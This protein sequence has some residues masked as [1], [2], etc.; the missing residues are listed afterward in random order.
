MEK[1]KGEYIIG[2]SS[3]M[4]S[5]AQPQEKIGMIDLANKA[6]YSAF[7]GVNFTQIDL[8]MSNEFMS[9][10]LK[11]KIE[12]M[13]N[14][15]KI[16]F[17]IHGVTTATG[18]KGG[19]MFLDSA[20][21]TEY[22]KAHQVLVKDLRNSSKIGAKYHLQHASETTPYATLGTNFQ[23][24]SLV[25]IWGRSLYIFLEE[26]ENLFEWVT[27]QKEAHILGRRL[28]GNS[29]DIE[30]QLIEN[31]DKDKLSFRAD[32]D[33]R[34]EMANEGKQVAANSPPE[35]REEYTERLMKRIKELE[36]KEKEAIPQR[37]MHIAKSEITASL[38][39]S[40]MTYGP[41]RFAYVVIAKWMSDKRDPIWL[42]IVGDKKFED[43]KN[44]TDLWVPAVSSKYIWGHFHPETCPGKCPEGV[45][46]PKPILEGEDG[47]EGIIFVIE[48]ATIFSGME[49]LFRLVNP[50]HMVKLSKHVRSRNFGV[51]IDFE[52]CLGA[53]IKPLKEPTDKK[54]D[55]QGFIDEMCAG[56]ANYVR[57]LHVGWPT[58]LNPAHAPIYLGSEQQEWLYRWIFALRKKGFDESQDRFIIFER[59]G[60]VGGDPVDQSTLALK[61]VVE[62]LRK[63]VT[64]EDLIKE[65]HLDFYGFDTGSYKMQESEIIQHAMDPIRGLLQIPEEQHGFLGS[66]VVPK[67]KGKEWEAGK[68][69]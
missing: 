5:M 15:L 13:K 44:K 63:E 31:I 57:V 68:M 10:D 45:S 61:K 69:R 27:R 53:G 64:P 21:D 18:G 46:D 59:A 12:R 17:G 1:P 7:K 4:F 29:E 60:G 55:P 65:E 56:D 24:T 23:P 34:S 67:G 66:Q 39:Q 8:E 35:I 51:A 22:L 49:D 11:T 58:P 25:D 40:T 30:K 41:E 9:P 62:Y 32:Q 50:K 36:D 47:R 28:G 54:S 3:G 16:Q 48:T 14:E 33:V 38:K 6:F 26:N 37:A 2:V 43:V 20:I 19:G 42:D 52:H